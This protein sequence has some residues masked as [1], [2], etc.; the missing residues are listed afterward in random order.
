MARTLSSL[1]VLA[2]V[3]VFSAGAAL[4]RPF[5]S[6]VARQARLAE[7]ALGR[8]NPL[9]SWKGRAVY[10]AHV[11]GVGE[12][13]ADKRT[14]ARAGNYSFNQLLRKARVLKRAGFSKTERR[15]LMQKGV[16]GSGGFWD[17][18]NQGL[19]AGARASDQLGAIRRIRNGEARPGDRLRAAGLNQTGAEVGA[20]D[21]AR[22]GDA[23]GALGNLFR[24]NLFGNDW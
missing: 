20:I 10:R 9:S 16:V 13:G 8:I 21:A 4:A 1:S 3:T 19:Q 22:R 18:L 23:R 17:A 11:I 6:P 24:A 7:K 15:V 12:L 2:C 14:P 5:G